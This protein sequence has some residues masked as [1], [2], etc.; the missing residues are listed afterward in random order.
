M[1]GCYLANTIIKFWWQVEQA[2][3][4][5]DLSRDLPV[6]SNAKEGNSTLYRKIS[7]D[8]AVA[9][10]LKRGDRYEWKFLD[11]K[12]TIDKLVFITLLM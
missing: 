12:I 1:Q 5:S 4:R 6:C 10:C 9:I 11:G 3:E 8:D 2:Y 7:G